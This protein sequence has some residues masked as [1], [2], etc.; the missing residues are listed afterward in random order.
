MKRVHSDI[1]P[2]VDLII[3]ET[4]EELK[5][6]IY[7]L[8]DDLCRIWILSPG[9]IQD[10]AVH[11]LR[12]KIDGFESYKKKVIEKYNAPTNDVQEI[13]KRTF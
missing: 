6:G 1:D 7:K 11:Y 9:T 8:T 5:D 10:G 3:Y 12:E 13:K 2:M 4:E